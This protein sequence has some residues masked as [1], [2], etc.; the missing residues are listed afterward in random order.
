MNPGTSVRLISDPGRQ[1]ITTGKQRKK[2]NRLLWQVAFPDSYQY[3]P[4]KQ[5]EIVNNSFEDAYDCKESN[6]LKQRQH[7][8]FEIN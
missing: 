6:Y 1:G 2:A 7:K 4:E 8:I 3:I 5:L